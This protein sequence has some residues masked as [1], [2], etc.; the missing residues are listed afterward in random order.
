MKRLLLPSLLMLV[1][2]SATAQTATF[3]RPHDMAKWGVPPGNYSGIAPLGDGRY[4][5]ISDK[6]EADGWHE[7]SISFT[8]SGDIESVAYLGAHYAPTEGTARDAEGIVSVAADTLAEASASQ[9][10]TVFVSAESD[11][12]ILELDLQGCPTGRELAVPDWAGPDAI[13]GNYGFEALAYDATAG[14]FWS[15][16]EHAL[17]ADAGIK[18]SPDYAQPMVLRLLHFGHDLSFRGSYAYRTDAPSASPPVKSYAFGVAELTALPY[19]RHKATGDY[20]NGPT[21][22]VLE[23]EVAVRPKFV[24]S[25]VRHCLYSVQ[26]L[27]SG[28]DA[29]GLGDAAPIYNNSELPKRLVGEFTT[30]LRL[31]GR[32]DFANYEGMC[33]GPVLADGRQTILLVA[34]SQNR[35]GNRIFQMKDYI[36]V[37]ILPSDRP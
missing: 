23:R 21:L 36:R 14:E 33:L 20:D 28:Q 13:Y 27:Q 35:F 11:Q 18:S 22:L 26:P 12:R 4:A 3:L 9:A 25:F 17:R 15:T 8:T 10:A 30:R 1:Q 19:P 2:L 31:A 37:A 24:G 34:D 5:L 29:T 16:T 32:R 7:I 6:Q